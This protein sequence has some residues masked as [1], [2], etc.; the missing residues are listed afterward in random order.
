MKNAKLNLFKFKF[1]NL[2][3]AM[4]NLTFTDSQLL[5]H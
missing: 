4:S 3:V 2:F 1:I 5:K